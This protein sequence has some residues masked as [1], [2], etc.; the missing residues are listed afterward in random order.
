MSASMQ[1]PPAMP[2]PVKEPF[3]AMNGTVTA[4]ELHAVTFSYP[5]FTL[6]PIEWS[7]PVGGRGAL[8]GANGAGKTTLLGILAGQL[9]PA[10]GTAII[11]GADC[12]T[13]ATHVRERVAF[14]AE[15][16]LCCPWMTARE[17]FRLQ[18]KFYP[19][20][21]NALAM[22]TARRLSLDVE[23]PLQALSRGN[24]LKAGIAN[25]LGQRSRVLLL[26]E[27]TAGLDPVARRDFM[28]L[29]SEQGVT[30]SGLTIL[31]AT[32]ILEDLDDLGADSL[33]VLKNGR[34]IQQALMNRDD[35]RSPSALAREYLLGGDA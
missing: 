1:L 35:T 29:L 33:L 9:S 17:H 18:E 13:D 23:V 3:L 2:S 22:D 4:L 32:H 31:F 19:A 5:A 30:D 34:A 14:V 21:N 10:A 6:G 20:W 16:L 11:A 8:V 15:R 25:A 26:D 27:P 12:A 7:L 24:S 28:R